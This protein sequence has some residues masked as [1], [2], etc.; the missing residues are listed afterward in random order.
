MMPEEH[1]AV[2]AAAF[3]VFLFSMIGLALYL[4]A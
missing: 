1:G 2:L 3:A 4:T